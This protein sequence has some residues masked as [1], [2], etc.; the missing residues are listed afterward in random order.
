MD[1]AHRIVLQRLAPEVILREDIGLLRKLLA[2]LED[3]R[4][5]DW[6]KG[7]QVSVWCMRAWNQSAYISLVSSRSCCIT[8]I[9][10]TVP[11]IC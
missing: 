3:A 9:F 8:A 1:R 5:V 11:R 10:V 7:G 2:D 6:H 4:I